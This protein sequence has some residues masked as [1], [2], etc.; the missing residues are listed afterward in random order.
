MFEARFRKP[1]FDAGYD[2]GYSV[3]SVSLYFGPSRTEIP[4]LG[5]VHHPKGGPRTE[6][7]SA[8]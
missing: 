6:L 4:T 8:D 3:R 2:V 7:V 5:S 1:P